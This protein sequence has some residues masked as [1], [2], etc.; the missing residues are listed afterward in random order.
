MCAFCVGTIS[1]VRQSCSGRLFSSSNLSVVV[2]LSLSPPWLCVHWG[3]SVNSLLFSTQ[4]D[5]VVGGRGV[6]RNVVAMQSFVSAGMRFLRVKRMERCPFSGAVVA[7]GTRWSMCIS[8]SARRCLW[9][10]LS[11]FRGWWT[12]HAKTRREGRNVC[13]RAVVR[14][15]DAAQKV[16]L[17]TFCEKFVREIFGLHGAEAARCSDE[18]YRTANRTL[19]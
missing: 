13:K 16:R 14:V 8:G 12:R 2:L 10:S 18:E 5:K 1:F 9:S 17:P 19:L 4:C 3:G 11:V 6:A 7:G 15:T